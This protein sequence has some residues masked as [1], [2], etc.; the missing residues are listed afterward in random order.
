MDILKVMNQIT[1]SKIFKYTKYL[2]YTFI[3]FLLLL[4]VLEQFF[5]FNTSESVPMGIYRYKFNKNFAKNDIVTFTKDSSYDK[6]LPEKLGRYYIKKLVADEYS[7]V[8]I[9]ND[10]IY[11]DGDD[12]GLI[13]HNDFLPQL[14]KLPIK[15][16]CFLALSK[17]KQSFDSR[18]YGQV[19]RKE[20]I[21]KAVLLHEYRK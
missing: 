1:A 19:C 5:V 8:I 6:F 3:G 14:L 20:I 15:K 12:Y 18:Y 13:Y 17:T 16:D 10:H 21:K 9:K 2:L 4:V 11:V 7:N